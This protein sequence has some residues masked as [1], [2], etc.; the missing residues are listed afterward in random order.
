MYRHHIKDK[1]ISDMN[2]TQVLRGRLHEVDWP[3]RLLNNRDPRITWKISARLLA[4]SIFY[5]HPPRL[6]LP[7]MVTPQS[8]EEKKSEGVIFWRHLWFKNP[9]PFV[10]KLA[11]LGWGSD[12]KMERPVVVYCLSKTLKNQMNAAYSS[13]CILRSYNFCLHK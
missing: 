2:V 9:T 4:R 8:F 11:I 3:S 13:F 12:K 7:R 10:Q 6:P 5:P 1:T